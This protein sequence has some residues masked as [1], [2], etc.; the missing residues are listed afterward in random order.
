VITVE[1]AVDIAR[2]ST[3]VFEFVADQTNAP[4]WQR[5]LE[6]VRRLTEGPIGVG[7]EHAFVRR[8][9]GRRVESRNRFTRYEP[10]RSVQFEI[11]DG[12]VTGTASYL[13]EPDEEGRCRLTSRM[14]FH[15]AGPAALAS[16]L[17]ARVLAKDSRRDEAALKALL[18]ARNSLGGD[19]GP[20]GPGAQHET[21]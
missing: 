19:G 9:A 4:R 16:P 1:S 18:E 15:I 20:S 10:G 12:W 21:S 11:R 13:V 2:P 3:E 6:E 17:L 7:T 14:D 8:F 5:G